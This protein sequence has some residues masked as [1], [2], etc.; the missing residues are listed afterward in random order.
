[1]PPHAPSRSLPRPLARA[2]LPSRLAPAT[3]AQVYERLLPGA[4]RPLPL[5][6]P[7]AVPVPPRHTAR[8]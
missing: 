5:S 7:A 2:F 8:A 6:S 3:L 1:M 4:R